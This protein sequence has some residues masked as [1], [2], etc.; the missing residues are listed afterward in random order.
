M[1]TLVV[2]AT[3]LLGSEICRQLAAAGRPIRAMVRSTSDPA[4]R[5]DLE[6]L[7]AEIVEAD[8]KEASSLL[9]A[10]TGA[11]AVISTA[12]STFS[13]QAGDSIDTVDRAGQLALVDAA[14]AARVGHFVFVSFRPNAAIEY[15]LTMAKRS[16][17]SALLVS[18]LDYTIL[19]AS[20]FM[21]VWLTPA[22]GFDAAGGHVKLFG[23]GTQ[24]VSW[25]AYRDVAR[26]AVAALDEP[27]ARNAVVELGGPEALSPR[28]VVRM[29]EAA[30]VANIETEVVPE[31]ALEAQMRS[32]PD[33]LGQSFAGLM[34]QCSRGDAIDPSH[35]QR[36]FPFVMSSVRDYI[37]SQ[38]AAR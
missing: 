19:Q 10:C 18:G 26:A 8:L 6:R 5:R 29:F 38:L 22:V 30:G 27:A 24:P 21:E 31:A 34:L 9:R 32:A 2:G 35:R 36:L 4:K 23:G 16:V 13:R 12:S 37:T 28:E 33:P 14:R 11:T 25:I 1:S 20:Y 3:G 17:E 15:P 7:G